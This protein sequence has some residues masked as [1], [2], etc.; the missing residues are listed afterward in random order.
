MEDDA[1]TFVCVPG[2][3]SERIFFYPI[4]ADVYFT[5]YFAPLGKV[6]GYDIS[7]IVM[8]Q[9]TLVDGKEIIIGAKDISKLL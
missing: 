8:V 1:E 3:V 7:I 2:I 5:S 6:E 9:E 4:Q